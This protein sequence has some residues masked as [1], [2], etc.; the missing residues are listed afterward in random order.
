MSTSTTHDAPPR[1]LP[2]HIV[3]RWQEFD[4]E[5]RA[6]WLRVIAIAAFYVVELLNFHGLSA[7]PV[8]WPKLA[9]IDAAFH[10]SVTAIALAGAAVSLCVLLCLRN[11]IFPGWLKFVST[12]GD[13]L[14]LTA[15][16][17]V[18]DGPR[19]PLVVAYFLIIA[20]STLRFSLTLVR[21][22]TVGTLVGYLC[23]N[24]YVRWF[25]HADLAVPRYH[26]VLVLISL[27][28][29]G[30]IAG[31]VI[32]SMKSMASEYAQRVQAGS[33]SVT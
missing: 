3:G 12:T 24:G 33:S 29:T 28:L 21:F 18:G 9:G 16:L 26:Q 6:N 13:L 22:A 7:G 32:R 5:S 8:E 10:R 19:T 23:V 25:G 20:L 15:F 11:R 14:L 30:I 1:D 31:Q 2:W 4:G 27:A 17:L